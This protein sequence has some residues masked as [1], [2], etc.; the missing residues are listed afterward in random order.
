MS[1]SNSSASSSPSP[2]PSSSTPPS[3]IPSPNIE[4]LALKET[5]VTDD[6]R[7][8]SSQIKVKANKAFQS[9]QE[10][11]PLQYYQYQIPLDQNFAEAA[12]LY[13]QAIDKNPFDATIYC[14]R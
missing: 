5:E 4:A 8:E 10:A 14:N 3:T 11:A 7:Q 6:D 9:E 1:G 12:T 2:S 13:S